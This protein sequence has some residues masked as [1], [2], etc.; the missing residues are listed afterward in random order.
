ML[1]SLNIA[2]KEWVYSQYDHE[3]QTRTIVKPGEGAAVISINASR[4]IALSSGC[5]PT[6]VA[7]DPFNGAA[8]TVLENAMNLAVKGATPIAFVNCLNF[9]NPEKKA[10]F[11]QLEQAVNGLS[12]AASI[13]E[14]PIVGGNVSLYNES[15]EFHTAIIPTPSIGMVGVLNDISKIPSAFF[16]EEGDAIIMVGETYPEYGGS[17]FAELFGL[18]GVA[19]KPRKGTKKNIEALVGAIETGKISAANDIGRGGILIALANMCARLGASVDLTQIL[20]EENELFSET[21]GRA[22]LTIKNQDLGSIITLLKTRNVPFA[23]IGTVVKD[24][25]SITIGDNKL[26]FPLELVKQSL[27]T[28]SDSMRG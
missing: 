26:T 28:L 14:T 1:S 2:S 24:R 6:Q 25:L 11:Y 15:E 9:G 20:G 7:A 13:I 18:E 5:N 12:Y 22:I 16:N 19:P 23:L 4:G 10:I 27:N 8:V 3:V 17:E 21:C